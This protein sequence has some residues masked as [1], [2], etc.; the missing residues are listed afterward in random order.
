LDFFRC[1]E[2]T[3]FVDTSAFGKE[4]ITMPRTRRPYPEEF[5]ERMI[6]LVRAGRTPEGLSREFEP[7]AQTVRNWVLRA[8]WDEG[9]RKGGLTTAERRGIPESPG[10]LGAVFLY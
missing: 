9:R 2:L 4:E 1:L 8:D 5:K 6:E 3:C 7:S 10:G